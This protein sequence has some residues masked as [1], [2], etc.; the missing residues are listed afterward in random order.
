MVRYISPPEPVGLLIVTQGASM[1]KSRP[2][3]QKRRKEAAKMEK[4]QIKA[5]RKAAREA[6]RLNGEVEGLNLEGL[7]LEGL[8]FDGRAIEEG[9]EE[10]ASAPDEAS[11]SDE[12]PASDEATAPTE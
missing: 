8:G 9:Q 10:G 3:V 7:G 5:A 6:A 2:S 4:A 12:A 11:A 1:A